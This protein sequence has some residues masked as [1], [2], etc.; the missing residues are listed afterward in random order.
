MSA[1]R[2]R[3]FAFAFACRKPFAHWPL[4]RF[5]THWVRS[6]PAPPTIVGTTVLRPPI[7]TKKPLT[8]SGFFLVGL[9]GL[10]PMSAIRNRVSA[11][12]FACRKSFAHWA[13]ASLHHPLGALG[14]GPPTI[15]GTTVLRPPI[16]TKK[17]LTRSGFFLVGLVGLEPMTPTMSTWCSNQLSY[18]PMRSTQYTIS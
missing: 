9:V 18:N 2:N 16:R 7:R 3:V 4:P 15:V 10:E 11:F 6:A 14:S 13:F 5:I 8:R 12:A 17:P 1:I